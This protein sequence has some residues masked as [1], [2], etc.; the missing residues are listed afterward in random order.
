MSILPK[1]IHR[2]NAIPNK[3]SMTYFADIEQIFQKFIWNHNQPQIASVI[4]RKKNKIGGIKLPDIKLYYK[5][6]C[7][8]NS[9][10]LA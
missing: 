7:N 8:Q 6:H 5:V 10:V 9:L 1:A 4:L 2:F 3:I